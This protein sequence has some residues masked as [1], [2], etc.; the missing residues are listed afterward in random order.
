MFRKIVSTLI[1][2][3]YLLLPYQSSALSFKPETYK[4]SLFQYKITPLEKE[5]FEDIKD[6]KLDRFTLLEAGLIAS[7]V[8]NKQKL[9]SYTQRADKLFEIITNIKKFNELNDYE[10]SEVILIVLHKVLFKKYIINATRVDAV[11]DR[12]IFNCVSSAVIYNYY[13]ERLGLKA[14]GILVP[15]HVFSAIRVKGELIDVETTTIYGFD[16][17]G[18]NKGNKS[19]ERLTGFKY[20]GENSKFRKTLDD[21]QLVAT[22]YSNRGA[23]SK[24][25]FNYAQGIANSVK[26]LN[27]Y[28]ELGEAE[29]NL[30]ANYVN[31]SLKLNKRKQY[32][33]SLDIMKEAITFLPDDQDVVNAYKVAYQLLALSLAQKKNFPK[34]IETI[35]EINQ[36]YPEDKKINNMYQRIYVLYWKNFLDKKQFQKA[37]N[38][39]DQGRKEFEHEKLLNEME[40]NTYI[41]WAYEFAQ[42]KEFDQA[43]QIIRSSKEKYPK[44]KELIKAF[45]LIHLAKGENYI[46]QRDYLN[47]KPFF[48]EYLKENPKD[49]KMRKI[50][51]DFFLVISF[52]ELEKKNYDQAIDYS[53]EGYAKFNYDNNIKKNLILSHLKK[54]EQLSDTGQNEK[55][56]QTL[57][58][59]IN[60]LKEEDRS[61]DIYEAYYQIFY[62]SAIKN[63][64]IEEGID[65]LIEDY[66]KDKKNRRLITQL[67]NQLMGHQLSVYSKQSQWDD[68]LNFIL[69][70]EQQLRDEKV[71]SKIKKAYILNWLIYLDKKNKY[72][73]GFEISEIGVKFFPEENKFKRYNKKFKNK[74]K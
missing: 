4:T 11:F 19:F 55:A 28:P 14:Y 1:I 10:K 63:K 41:N 32:N 27:M 60:F 70:K 61:N 16:P 65:T 68:G 9:D 64:K 53:K 5:L 12:G 57:G 40:I 17:T 7:G 30:K 45:H 72:K 26:A 42:K 69:A 73:K 49:S 38:L 48:E 74:I 6:N 56:K 47:G 22:I 31:W 24:K 8:K 3:L 13:C 2:A 36:L 21:I 54:I 67:L 51:I 43:I 44:D 34:S 59:L 50:Y 58:D 66:Q 39:V 33:K 71:F 52:N 37:L 35:Q 18:K 15:D 46:V 20:Y 62:N 25:D 23:D 29:N